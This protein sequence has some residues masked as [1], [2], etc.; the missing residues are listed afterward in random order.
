VGA[1]SGCGGGDMRVCALDRD[2]HVAKAAEEEDIELVATET[3]EA[4]LVHLSEDRSM[5]WSAGGLDRKRVGRRLRT[6]AQH[7]PCRARG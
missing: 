1:V 5:S 2:T 4:A 7:A 3:K 6:A